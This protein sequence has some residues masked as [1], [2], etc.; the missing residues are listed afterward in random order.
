MRN[1]I[2]VYAGGDGCVRERFAV[3]VWNIKMNEYPTCGTNEW[4]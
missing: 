1:F 4:L 2:Y 3:K